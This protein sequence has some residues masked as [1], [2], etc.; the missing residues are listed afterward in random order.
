MNENNPTLGDFAAFGGEYCERCGAQICFIGLN[1]EGN[2]MHRCACGH[3]SEI[4]P[5]F[6]GPYGNS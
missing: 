4:R 5:A 3:L 6:N 1:S 2:E